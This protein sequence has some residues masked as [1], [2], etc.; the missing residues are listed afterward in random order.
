[1]SNYLIEKSDTVLVRD[2]VFKVH[3]VSA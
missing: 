2:G 1:M 3:W